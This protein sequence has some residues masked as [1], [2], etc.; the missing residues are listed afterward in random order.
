[1]SLR[2]Q[3]IPLLP[4]RYMDK[5][6]YNQDLNN[7]PLTSTGYVRKD[8]RKAVTGNKSNRF[9]FIKERLDYET[10]EM[11]H[12][13]FRGGNTHANRYHVNKLLKRVGS[14]D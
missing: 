6:H 3:S 14:D 12:T 10:F 9:R 2:N 8:C 7:L 1:M 4:D 13:A 5:Y 11:N